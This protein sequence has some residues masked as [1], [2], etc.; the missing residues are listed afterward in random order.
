M[1][2]VL[3]YPIEINFDLLTYR[4]TAFD[5]V[6]KFSNLRE[7][8]EYIKSTAC[9]MHQCP[10]LHTSRVDVICRGKQHIFTA[11]PYEGICV[12]KILSACSLD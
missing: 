8:V 12:D 1:M 7:L 2:S 5:D 9:K 6:H 10:V 4:D 11:D 3:D